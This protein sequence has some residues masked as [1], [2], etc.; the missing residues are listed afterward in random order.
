MDPYPIT[1]IGD[2][3]EV[4]QPRLTSMILGAAENLAKTQKPFFI[5]LQCFG[6]GVSAHRLVGCVANRNLAIH[7]SWRTGGVAAVAD[8]RG[9]AGDGLPRA[10]QGRARAA[11]LRPLSRVRSTIIAGI[12]TAFFQ[13]CQHNDRA[14]RDVFPNSPSAWNAV[15]RVGL[16][17]AELTVILKRS[18]KM[19]L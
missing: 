12:W 9:D 2:D 1:S 11:I 4:N 6:G 3:Q 16:E 19:L 7:V 18:F 13:E 8:G 14:D 10:D 17:V 5:V 15:R